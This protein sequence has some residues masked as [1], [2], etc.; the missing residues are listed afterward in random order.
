MIINRQLKTFIFLIS[1]V[2]ILSL[3]YLGFSQLS[4]SNISLNP[5]N[6]KE[7]VFNIPKP[8]VIILNTEIPVEI[9]RSPKDKARGLSGRAFLAENEGFLFIFENKTRPSFWMKEMLFPIDIIWIADGKIVGIE[10]YIP[11]PEEGASLSD[12]PSYTP[13]SSIDYVLEVNAGFSDKYS[14]K[15]GDVVNLP[16]EVLTN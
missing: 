8:E 9:M 1:V 2:L 14:F 10:K 7:K 3:S 15:E 12:L 16:N 6:I 11:I 5:G 13:T 4:K